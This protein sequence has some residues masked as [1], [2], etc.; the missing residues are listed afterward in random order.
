MRPAPRF[1]ATSAAQGVWDSRITAPGGQPVSAC[2]TGPAIQLELPTRREVIHAGQH[3]A[4][5][6]LG[7]PVTQHLETRALEKAHTLLH[8]CIELMI[9]RHGPNT[10]R[11]MQRRKHRAQG[12]CPA[13][14]AVHHV[15]YQHQ[16]VWPQIIDALCQP[17]HPGLA[18]QAAQVQV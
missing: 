6:Y 13:H 4:R 5:R 10:Q 11:G 14:V 8:S 7:A 15:A 9:A 2:S 18:N 16:E 12:F 1:A 17:G 3:Q